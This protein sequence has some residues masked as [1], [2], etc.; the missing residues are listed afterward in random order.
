[1]RLD[2]LLSRASEQGPT[3]DLCSSVL[4]LTVWGAGF[5][6]EEASYHYSVVKVWTLGL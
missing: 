4:P 3:T 5:K 6:G 1:M 2:H